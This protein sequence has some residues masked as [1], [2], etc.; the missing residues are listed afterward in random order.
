MFEFS[1]LALIIAMLLA[2]MAGWAYSVKF[3]FSSGPEAINLI[4]L[5]SSSSEA[6]ARKSWISELEEIISSNIPIF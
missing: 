3:N 6:S 2:R 1:F 5:K 4:K